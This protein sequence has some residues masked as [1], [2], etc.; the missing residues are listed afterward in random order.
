MYE[1]S[2]KMTAKMERK[3]ALVTG[4]GSGFG[5]ATALAFAREGA[6]V[7]VADVFEEGGIETIHLIENAGGKA[8]YIKCDVS[9]A[10][11]VDA[12][13]NKGVGTYGRLDYVI[14]NPI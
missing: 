5:R 11:E 7:V 6:R 2:P 1:W 3:V 13:V 4:G 10:A 14:I 8:I 9:K 12:M